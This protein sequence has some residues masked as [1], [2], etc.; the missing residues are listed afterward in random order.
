MIRFFPP[1]V[2]GSIITIIG[3]SL[4][5]V[6]VN[7]AAGGVGNKSY[8]SG[9]FIAVAAVVLITILLI[10][11][12]FKG[13]VAHIAVLIGLFVGL[14]VAI[15]LGLVNFSGVAAAPWV[16][17]DVPFAFGMPVFDIGSIRRYDAG[18]VGRYGRVHR[19]F[20]GDRRDGRKEDW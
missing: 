18:Y 11:K 2:T 20:P 8:G 16:G 6:G 14:I 19:G 5:P 17:I 9:T 7:W 10:N 1:I 12:F 3:I 15:P 13:F 4:L